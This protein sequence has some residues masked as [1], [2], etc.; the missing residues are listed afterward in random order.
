MRPTRCCSLRE[1]FFRLNHIRLDKHW[2][3]RP[4]SSSVRHL[5]AVPSIHRPV[6]CL[7]WPSSSCI[8]STCSDGIR[9]LLMFPFPRTVSNSV[10]Q[11]SPQC[12]TSMDYWCFSLK[13]RILSSYPDF[14]ATSSSPP[15]SSHIPC[16]GMTVPWIRTTVSFAFLPRDLLVGVFGAPF[17]P[18]LL[19][20]PCQ[21]P[22]W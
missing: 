17:G 18:L 12:D 10:S 14:D 13:G 4:A 16:V 5:L 8:R 21:R 15:R 20:P 9:S 19:W 11:S 3:L 22:T 6:S 1:P 2:G 7:H